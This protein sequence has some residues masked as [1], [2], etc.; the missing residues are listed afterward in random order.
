MPRAAFAAIRDARL[1]RYHFPQGLASGDPTSDSVVLWTRVEA[2]AGRAPGRVPVTLQVSGTPDFTRERQVTALASADH[3]V[4]VIVTG[5]QPDRFY[6]Y[7]F[8]ADGDVSDLVGRTRTAPPP[9]A[10]RPVRLAFASCQSYEA[11]YYGAWRLL[12]NEDAARPESEQLD[13]VVHLGDFVYEALGYGKARRIAGLPSGGKPTGEGTTWA[14]TYAE[15]LDDYRFLYRTYLSDPDLRAAR[16]RWPF[17]VTWDDHEFTD[18]CWQTA[19]T[20]NEPPVPAQRRR[21]AA[22]Q[23]WF[24]YIPACLTGRGDTPDGVP[25]WPTSTPTASAASRTTSRP[26][27]H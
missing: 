15:T 22:S 12:L 14:E 16:A 9:D 4:R 6:W 8:I 7:R 3:T 26:S 17:V 11:G 2:V 18:D 1:A 20:Y 23:A 5:L 13:F 24:E 10:D 25:R 21:V 27:G 19:Q